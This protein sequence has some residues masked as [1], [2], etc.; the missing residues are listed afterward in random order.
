M[1]IY[2]L[3]M[4]LAIAAI[5]PMTSKALIRKRIVN[6]FAAGDYL[7]SSE[8]LS[9]DDLIR[10]FPDEIQEEAKLEVFKML[11]EHL[12]LK[13]TQNPNMFRLSSNKYHEI[14]MIRNARNEVIQPHEE[15]I[16]DGYKKTPEFIREGAKDSKGVVGKYFYYNRFDDVLSYIVYIVTSINSRPEKKGLGSLTEKD[17]ILS[18]VWFAINIKLKKKT[19]HKAELD[20]IIADHRIVQNRQP[21]KAAIDVLEYLGYIRKTGNKRG[22]SEEYQITDK[23]PPET[24]LDGF[25]GG[26]H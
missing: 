9:L 14:Q 23:R 21:I 19:F 8:E 18:V 5:L 25:L 20:T 6:E 16:P 4:T 1:Y 15:L 2:M 3:D 24:G 13:D 17:S 26:K 11:D 10:D 12:L 22:K 7:R